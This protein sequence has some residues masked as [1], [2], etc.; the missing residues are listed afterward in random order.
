[1]YA[2]HGAF[3]SGCVPPA[4]FAQLSVCVHA[5]HAHLDAGLSVA[6]GGVLSLYHLCYKRG[7]PVGRACAEG[8]GC[9]CS[10]IAC[11]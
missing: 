9:Y 11:L 5:N 8:V 7:C 2:R 6:A 3:A 10:S 4:L 1:M